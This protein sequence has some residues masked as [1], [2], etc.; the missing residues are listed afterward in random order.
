MVSFWIK[1]KGYS[2][3]ALRIALSVTVVIIFWGM[4]QRTE[5][6][7]CCHR[8]LIIVEEVITSVPNTTTNLRRITLMKSL[9]SWETNRL[10]VVSLCYMLRLNMI[11][12]FFMNEIN[13]PLCKN[14][15]KRNYSM[16]YYWQF[17]F[18]TTLYLIN[19]YNL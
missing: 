10:I 17:I 13:V 15:I 8:Y 7:C 9:W 11:S 6:N 12:N 5:D 2:F 19:C 4:W 3:S 1:E 18:E 16:I 14:T